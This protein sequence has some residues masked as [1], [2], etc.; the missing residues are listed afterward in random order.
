M[1]KKILPAQADANASTTLLD[2]LRRMAESM[3][4][5]FFIYRAEGDEEILYLNDVMLDIFGCTSEKEFRALTGGTFKGLVYPDDVKN[6]ENSILQQVEKNDKRLDYVQYRIKRKDGE[7]RWVDDYGRLIRTEEG[8]DV[9]YVFIRDITEIR[10]VQEESLRRARV[11]EGLSVGYSSIFLLNLETGSMFPYRQEHDY[12]ERIIS[13]LR[14]EGEP[15]PDFRLVLSEYASRFVLTEDQ[16]FFSRQT[17]PAHILERLA[18]APS[19]TV[20]YRCNGNIYMEMSVVRVRDEE[21]VN[22]VVLGFRNVTDRIARVQHE[23]SE[24]MEIEAELD[25]EKRA[26]EIKSSFLFSISHDIR[27]PMNAITGFT[28]LAKNHTDDPKLLAEML[29]HVEEASG[30]LMSLIDNLLEMSSLSQQKFTLDELPASLDDEISA[31]VDMFRPQAE[32]KKIELKADVNLPPTDV[33]LDTVRFRRLISNLVDNAIKFTPEGGHVTVAAKRKFASGSGYARYEFSVSD[34]GAGMAEGF[35]RRVGKVFEREKT[36]TESGYLGTGLGLAITK[37]ILD[38]MGGSMDVKSE[39]GKG[40]TFTISIPLK[41][42]GA[43]RKQLSPTLEKKEDAKADDKYRLL[44]AEDM[45]VN[46]LLA[47]TMLTEA[48]FEVE[49]VPDGCDA[50]DAVEGHPEYY[51]DAVLMDI[52]M[53]IMNGYEATRRI[54]ALGREDTEKLPIIALSANA[55]EQDKRAS[56]ESGMNAHVAKPFDLAILV[57][58]LNEH[59]AAAREE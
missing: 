23:L 31:I 48:G 53:P 16:A 24:K 27:T 4:G 28:A 30:H 45:G 43:A 51:Y 21:R 12:F 50:L 2:T 26:N 40:S 1:S 19:Y 46:R 44:L 39:K 29:G 5:G 9:Y 56:L 32:E 33:L 55:R 14:E 54:R 15:T 25:R 37:K 3:P 52:Q 11:I 35:L 22:N 36:S 18:A 57:D 58:I 20:T 34:D 59:I 42:A 8:D 6:V 38:L 49:S 10:A 17:N 13:E 41:Q 7:I 47:E